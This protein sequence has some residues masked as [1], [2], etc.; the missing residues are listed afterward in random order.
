MDKELELEIKKFFTPN[1]INVIQNVISKDFQ[2]IFFVGQNS[3]KWANLLAK[4]VAYKLLCPGK[5]CG[6]CSAC[7]M[8]EKNFHPDLY[9]KQVSP[10]AISVA[11]AR[12]VS[13]IA[14]IKPK[15]AKKRLIVIPQL[16]LADEAISVLLK[17]VEEPSVTTVFVLVADRITNR[18]LTLASRSIVI[19]ITSNTIKAVD[20]ELSFWLSVKN[21]LETS[22]H[23]LKKIQAEIKDFLDKGQSEL[24]K[25]QQLEKER[26]RTL[27]LKD[28][29]GLN[30]ALADLEQYHHRELRHVRM[31]LLERG[32]GILASLYLNELKDSFKQSSPKT[33]FSEKRKQVKKIQ[34]LNEIAKELVRNPNEDALIDGIL[35]YLAS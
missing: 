31:D 7:M 23:I 5:G 18:A 4:W 33:Y 13:H 8:I 26:M 3:T 29:D 25:S 30:K 6:N 2:S 1:S 12:E 9:F 14:H 35:F 22:G 17:T 11:E 20:D 24:K 19:N 34:Y 10:R 28:D 15:V 27:Y 32:L 16:H 21:R